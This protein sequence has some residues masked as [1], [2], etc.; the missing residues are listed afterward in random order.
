MSVVIGMPWRRKIV[1]ELV[2]YDY[3][4][5]S[6]YTRQS[7]QTNTRNAHALA[8]GCK[9]TDEDRR[10]VCESAS[11]SVNGIRPYRAVQWHYIEKLS[12]DTVPNHTLIT[13]NHQALF[14]YN[15]TKIAG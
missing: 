11:E 15:R 7:T 3:Q 9:T 12:N 8:L 13:T 5:G 10:G 6:R 1:Q 14:I 2:V 4:S